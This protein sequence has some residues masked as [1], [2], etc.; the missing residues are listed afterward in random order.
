MGKKIVQSSGGGSHGKSIEA[1]REAL[2]ALIGGDKYSSAAK[3]RTEGY[4]PIKE[5]LGSFCRSH[6]SKLL[7]E[8]HE[9]G[10]VEMVKVLYLGRVQNWYRIPPSPA[11]AQGKQSRR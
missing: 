6:A 4:L 7:C 1:S 9:R 3:A 11:K 2:V 10:E 8:A 5:I